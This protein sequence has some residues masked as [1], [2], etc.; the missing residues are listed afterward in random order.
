MYLGLKVRNCEP[1]IIGYNL[2][3][4][5]SRFQKR[6]GIAPTS[7]MQAKGDPIRSRKGVLI[8]RDS[9]D[10]ISSSSTARDR[11]SVQVVQVL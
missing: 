1:Y 3:T 10:I 11:L 2:G 5:S 4:V 6:F 7:T 9:Y 8:R